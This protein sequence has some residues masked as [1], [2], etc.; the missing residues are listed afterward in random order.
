MKPNYLRYLKFALRRDME[1]RGHSPSGRLCI[2][3]NRHS[4][5]VL[6]DTKTQKASYVASFDNF[7]GEEEMI[8]GS[9]GLL[10]SHDQYKFRKSVN[11]RDIK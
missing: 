6:I 10:D 3:S 7:G 4:Y 5:D 9:Y 8:M 11:H 2:D 1:K